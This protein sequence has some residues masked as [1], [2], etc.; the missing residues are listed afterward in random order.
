MFNDLLPQRFDNTYH[1]QKFALWLL[2]FLAL[3]KIVMGLNCIFNGYYV[4][5]AADG[6]P[7]A[8]YTSAGAQA[9]VS[10][11]AAWG[12]SVFIFGALS[13]LIL[14]RYRN[15]VPFILALLLTE[16][17]SRKLIFVF[18]PI[19]KLEGSKG[20]L[21]NLVLLAAM[22]VG[23]VLSLWRSQGNRAEA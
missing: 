2:G 20:Y 11:F 5:T 7:L 15:M 22:I 16:H 6:I 10:M 17:L 12:L 18:L 14:V 1:G 9:V 4:A 21:V 23:L 3:S 8:N 19:A 13:V